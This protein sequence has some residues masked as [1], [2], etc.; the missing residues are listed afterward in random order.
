MFWAWILALNILGF[1]FYLFGHLVMAHF[2]T[3]KFIPAQSHYLSNLFTWVCIDW[4]LFVMAARSF[5]YAA[6]LIINLDVP[7]VYPF[8]PFCSHLSRGS[9]NIRKIYGLSVLPYIVPLCI[10]IGFVFLKC[11]LVNMVLEFE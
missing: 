1:V 9:R 4:R 6:K 2:G 11:S 5:A 10:G 7:N 3:P 8:F